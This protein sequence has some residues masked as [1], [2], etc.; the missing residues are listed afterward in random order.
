MRDPPSFTNPT[1]WRFIKHESDLW[2]FTPYPTIQFFGVWD[3]W[4]VTIWFAFWGIEW[5]RKPIPRDVK[6]PDTKYPSFQGDDHGC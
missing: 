2:I 4:G 5:W 6:I 1:H 3:N